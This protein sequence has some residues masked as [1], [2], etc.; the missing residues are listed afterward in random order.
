M[1]LSIKVNEMKVKIRQEEGEYLAYF[2]DSRRLVGVNKIGSVI[3]NQLFNESKKI[4]AITAEISTQYDIP[5][6][7]VRKDAIDFLTALDKEMLPDGFAVIDQ[8]QMKAP[9]GVELEIT[10]ACNLRCKHC[11][12]DG[13][14]HNVSMKFSKVQS[15]IDTLSKAGVCEVSLIGGEPF[16]HKDILAII[17]YCQNADMTVN[18]V[19]NST[20]LTDDIV[21]ELSKFKRLSLLVS[22]DGISDVHDYIRGDGVFI[23]VSDVLR[24]LKKNKI[25]V[26]T[27]CTLN[28]F[29]ITNYREVLDYCH[30]LKIPCNFNL[31]KPFSEKHRK[32]TLH[33][34][35]FFDTIIELLDLRQNHGYRVGLSNAAII[36]ELFELPDR[37]ECR[38]TRS[39]LVIDVRGRMITCPSLVAT[40]FY[41]AIKLP[42]FS[43]NFL[44]DWKNHP[45]FIDFQQ[46]GLRECQA[47]AMIFSQ[48]V[49]GADPYGI[50][51][52]K[53]YFYG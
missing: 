6:S 33:P 41:D 19:T 15:I 4:K 8:K 50:T 40:G 30:N 31:F 37:N 28:S 34:H 17:E 9:L 45:V 5:L 18:V 26:E 20:L 32:L 13:G 14:H 38:A 52:F 25:A 47:R 29:N 12:Q 39:G 48:D 7:E 44:D 42:E 16:L 3:L 24:K 22:L 1:S 11:I 53:K 35:D 51:A 23:K 43:D 27:L 21:S 49:N 2:L 10:T 46:K 36:A